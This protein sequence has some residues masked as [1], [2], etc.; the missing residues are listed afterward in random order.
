V[1]EIMNAINLE[2]DLKNVG[3]CVKQR[4]SR[5]KKYLTLKVGSRRRRSVQIATGS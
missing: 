5:M 1:G 3:I 4:G 2:E